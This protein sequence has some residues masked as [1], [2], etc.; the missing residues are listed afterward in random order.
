MQTLIR[1]K[2]KVSTAS[3]CG[4][5]KT[6]FEVVAQMFRE[7]FLGDVEF[8]LMRN[9]IEIIFCNEKMLMI[10]VVNQNNLIFS[11]RFE[12]NQA[13]HLKQIKCLACN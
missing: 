6:R 11:I 13:F 2:S 7:S 4:M 9:L 3:L 5:G 10:E 12:T 1:D 8:V